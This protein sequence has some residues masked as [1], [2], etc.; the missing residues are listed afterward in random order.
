MIS[1]GSSPN[2]I[3]GKL[4]SI[5]NTNYKI[6][7]KYLLVFGLIPFLF[8]CNQGKIDDLT[9]QNSDL[10]NQSAEYKSGWDAAV[11][12]IGEYMGMMNEI[13]SSL[14]EIKRTEGI[15]NSN[16]NSE[17]RSKQQQKDE[18]IAS[19]KT[20]NELIQK[21]KKLVA[22]LDKKYKN[23]NFKV[24]QLDE[25]IAMLNEQLTI[26]E[27][28]LLAL[29]GEL[30]KANYQI[31]S[32]NTELTTVSTAKQQLE[33]QTTEQANV[34]AKQTEDLNT[35]Y[36]I[37]GSYKELKELG[38]VDKE[39]GFIGIGSNKELVNNFDASAFTKVDIRNFKELS[40]NS[41]SAKVIT[42]HSTSS[43][44]VVEGDK[45]IEEIKIDNPDEFW[46]SSKFLVVLTD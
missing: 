41:K 25:Q 35:A 44:T 45:T 10:S 23:S 30:E 12:E 4:F 29:K 33:V 46:K 26:K 20:L 13:D 37:A 14:M 15:I 21:N 40:I 1:K 36:Y 17:G 11:N 31:V 43:Y 8:A 34:I 2:E 16:L 19:I 6:M 42:T 7:K 32:L 38:V 27:S 5:D 22:E 18:M 9:K 39:G 3:L 24:K 28:D